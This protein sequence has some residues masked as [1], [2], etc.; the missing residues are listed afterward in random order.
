LK[1]DL[2]E[3]SLPRPSQRPNPAKTYLTADCISSH[4]VFCCASTMNYEQYVFFLNSDA[5]G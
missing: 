3:L 5:E 2:I 4:T 1:K